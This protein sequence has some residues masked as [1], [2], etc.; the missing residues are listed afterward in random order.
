MINNNT[1]TNTYTNTNTN[2]NDNDNDNDN[3]ES[4]CDPTAARCCRWPPTTP[5]SVRLHDND[6]Y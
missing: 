3:N 5:P 2:T 1:N 6:K 4:S